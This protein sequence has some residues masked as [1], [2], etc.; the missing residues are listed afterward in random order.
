MFIFVFY[1]LI[2]TFELIVY[3][4]SLIFVVVTCHCHSVITN[5]GNT[6]LH[7]GTYVYFSA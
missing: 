7:I 5:L 6:R 3:E 1:S 4:F 2:Y